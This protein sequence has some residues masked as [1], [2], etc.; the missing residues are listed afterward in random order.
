[1]ANYFKLSPSYFYTAI[2]FS[3]YILTILIVLLL[4]IMALAKVA[5]AVLLLSA[6]FYYLRRDAWLLSS[7]S[8]VAIRLEGSVITLIT[9]DHSELIGTVSRD[10]VVTPA[11]T[12]VNVE[13]A[14]KG[15][16]LSV[17]IFPDSLEKQRNR[18][19]RVLL[20]WNS[21]EERASW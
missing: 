3:V 8:Y 14:E 15:L 7:S 21:K 1:M 5:I 9:R 6:L 13:L 18:E 19:L 10:S 20:K 2:L 12:V 11:L 4:P 16:S 17:V